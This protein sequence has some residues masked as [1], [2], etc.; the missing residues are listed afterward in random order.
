LLQLLALLVLILALARPWVATSEPVG[1]HVIIVVDTSASMASADADE[2][3]S[4]TRLEAAQ[5]QADSIVDN[6]PQD[7]TATLI[8]SD[9]HASVLVPAT[10]DRARLREAIGRLRPQVAGTDMTE[11]IKLASI[12]ASRQSNSSVWVLSDGAFPSVKDNV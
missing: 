5:Q 1:Q 8:S 4:K 2:H 3:G 7:G 10:G 9:A 11:A 12:M 6:L